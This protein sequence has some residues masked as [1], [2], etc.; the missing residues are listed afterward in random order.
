MSK[1]FRKIYIKKDGV[2]YKCIP[3][4]E[5]WMQM[6]GIKHGEDRRFTFTELGEDV[7]QYR[8]NT[9]KARTEV[10]EY[11]NSLKDEWSFYGK[12]YN[13]SK[14]LSD[15]NIKES[16]Y[17]NDKYQDWFVLKDIPTHEFYTTWTDKLGKEHKYS[18]TWYLV[19]HQG[20]IYWMISYHYMPQCQ[21][22]KFNGLDKEPADFIKWTH[23]KNL[24][25]VWNKT[26]KCYV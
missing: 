5:L 11:W 7:E 21:L 24:K 19:W 4:K 6:T 25:A 22:Y 20:H 23:I 14:P 16:K 3:E 17:T 1:G 12:I 13:N 2:I 18:Y 8:Y 10:N 15:Y 9:Q 26:D